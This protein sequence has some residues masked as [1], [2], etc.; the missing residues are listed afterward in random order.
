MLRNDESPLPNTEVHHLRSDNVGDEF[1][2]LL[3]HSGE[4]AAGPRPV[5]VLAD[6]WA[7]FG[8]AVEMMRVL[9]LSESVPDTVVVA[10][11][12]RSARMDDIVRLR[13]RD[14]TPTVDGSRLSDSQPEAMM[15]GADAFLA[16]LRDEL[17]PW[18]AGRHGADPAD[19]TFLGYSLGGLFATHVLLTAPAA[20]RRYAI[21]SPSLWWDERVAFATEAA[22][23][24]A[25]DD[26]AGRVHFSVGGFETIAGR[27]RFIEQLPPEARAAVEAEDA[28]DPPVDMVADMEE[29]VATLRGRGY[30]SL[31]LESEVLPG[32]YHETGPPIAM[33][34]ALRWLHGAPR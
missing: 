17:S 27:R 29:M 18:L 21:G 1:K 9:R 14:L 34:R 12:Y 24:V 25:N 2:V 6:P 7:A 10:V 31:E 3:A 5:L 19:S 20:F 4:P 15:A 33:S 13:T 32:E 23:A 26:L 30:R 8:T 16:F 22:Y 28:A 11:G